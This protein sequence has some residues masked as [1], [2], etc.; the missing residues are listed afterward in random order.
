M[1]ERDVERWQ[2]HRYLATAFRAAVLTVPV[3]AAVASSHGLSRLVPHPEGIAD[4][5]GWW[6]LLMATSTVVLW[7][8]DRQARR[9][10]PVTVLL[11]LSLVFPDRAPSRW[12]AAVRVGTTRQLQCR[13]DEA[14]HAADHDE[15]AAEAALR[16][17]ELAA[18]LGAHDRRTRG[19]SERVRGY[20]RLLGQEMGLTED[21]LDKL[22]WAA[23]LHDI[24]KLGVPASVLNKK[25][26][27]DE[28]DLAG[29]H[30]H[31]DDGWAMLGPLRSWLGPWALAVREHHERWDG[32]GYP[33]RLK[34]E[35]ISLGAR[36][37][38]V[39][40]AFDAMTALR[41][42]Q[43]PKPA[44]AARLELARCAGSHFDP[45]VVRTFVSLSL[46]R[47]WPFMGPLSWLAQLPL[48]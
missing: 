39:A 30:R 29:I 17:L 38:S 13:I 12:G 3:A 19:H 11:K 23:L 45:E 31:P 7:A 4:R 32:D 9:L 10:L 6:A 14:K 16:V 42:Y 21:D 35:E 24:G 2:A 43:R 44:P 37:V 27:L 46:G 34:G 28:H 8:L 1:V 5:V 40:D 41:S 18:A 48:F 15:T 22:N 25:D 36:I 47:M 20:A 33:R 26:E